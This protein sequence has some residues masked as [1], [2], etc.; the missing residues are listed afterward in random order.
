L[1]ERLYPEPLE[2]RAEESVR[3]NGNR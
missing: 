1:G 2:R 3:E